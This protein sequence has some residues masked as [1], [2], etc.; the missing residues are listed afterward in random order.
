M[1][2]GGWRIYT[3]Q[4]KEHID[5][6]LTMINQIRGPSYFLQSAMIPRETRAKEE[7]KKRRKEEEKEKKGRRKEEEKK[8]KSTQRLPI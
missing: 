1:G 3:P 6:Q 7:K 2:G 8:K 5:I 4:R